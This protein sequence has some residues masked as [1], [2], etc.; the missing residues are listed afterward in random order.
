MTAP[1]EASFRT[2]L[3]VALVAML[4]GSSAVGLAAAVSTQIGPGATETG[5]GAYVTEHALTYWTWHETVLTT[6]P[7]PAPARAATTV[8]APTVLP[9]G[10]RT[11]SINAAT[12]GQ[13]AV[14]WTFDELTTV[15][16]NTEL[17]IT[18]LDG[19]TSPATSIT[20]Y[21]ETNARAPIDTTPYV[22]YW[23]A[24]TF[25][26]ATLVVETM[27]TT[28]VACTAVGNCP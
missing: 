18:F 2:G 15:P 5:Q 6:I 19:L 22:F 4:V 10:A 11:F 25:A 28:A 16:R 20:V 21:V 1:R 14:E 17:M 27:T 26:P 3:L 12:G 23:D 8:A 9:R 24:G 7:A 13:V